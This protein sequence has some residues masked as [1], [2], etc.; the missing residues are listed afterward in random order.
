MDHFSFLQAAIFYKNNFLYL[1]Q[2][3]L[4]Y[5]ENFEVYFRL[6]LQITCLC[7]PFGEDV[8]VFLD[9]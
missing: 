1:N 9:F 7:I 8:L 2:I 5:F 6:K 4:D 3:N